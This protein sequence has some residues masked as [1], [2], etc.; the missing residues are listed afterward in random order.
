[1][2]SSSA[3]KTKWL[4]AINQAV[5]QA[6][7][8]AAQDAGSPGSKAEPP[9]S[10]TASYTFYKDGRLKDATYEGRWLAGK[11]HGRGILKWPDGR[12]YTGSFKNGLED[13]FGEFICPNKA[14]NKD[15]F[16]QGYWKEGKMHGLGTYR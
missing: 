4:R 14:L 6:L 2:A 10:R 11:P 1:M 3:E 15:D 12:I 13:G 16:Y 8:G 7:N 9:I 5:D